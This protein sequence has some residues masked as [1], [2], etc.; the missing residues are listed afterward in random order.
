MKKKLNFT[1]RSVFGVLIGLLL[2]TPIQVGAIDSTPAQTGPKVLPA[3]G[4]P[5]YTVKGYDRS[6]YNVPYI[7]R[8]NSVGEGATWY[9]HYNARGMNL[10]YREDYGDVTIYSPIP[11]APYRVKSSYT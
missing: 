9:N 3:S 7:M 5:W 8:F 4:T 6:T 2:L 10:I 1:Q 11:S